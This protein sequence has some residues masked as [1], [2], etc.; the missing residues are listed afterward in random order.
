MKKTI[1][2]LVS[3]TTFFGGQ[4]YYFKVLLYFAMKMKNQK[5]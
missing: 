4:C 5:Y 1:F 3:K 2:Y